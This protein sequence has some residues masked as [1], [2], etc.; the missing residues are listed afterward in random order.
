MFGRLTVVGRQ[1]VLGQQVG[2][3]GRFRDLAEL[4]LL[5]RPVGAAHRREVAAAIPRD[6]IMGM[7]F[8]RD[9]QVAVEVVLGDLLKLVKQFQI[10][11]LSKTS[12]LH[13]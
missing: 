3:H 2:D 13:P 7:P 11:E 4:G 5:C 8:H 1:V 6:V 12:D 9:R 10:S